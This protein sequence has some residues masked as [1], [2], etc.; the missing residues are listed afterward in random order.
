MANGSNPQ[1]NPNAMPVD[2]A[3]LRAG[4]MAGTGKPRIKLNLDG[5]YTI[6]GVNSPTAFFSP[7]NPL[8]PV[9]QADALGRAFD[10]PTGYNTRITPRGEEAI[11]FAQLKSMA[12]GFDVLRLIIETRK[13][14]VAAQ[15]WTIAPKDD[16]QERDSRCDEVQKFFERPDR[17]HVWDDWMRMV[18][19]QLFVLDAVSLYCQPTRGGDLFGLQV[20]D[21]ATIK[22]VIT[23]DG[24]TPMPDE[25][26]AYQEVIKGLPA[27]DYVVATPKGTPL[28]LDEYGQPMPE[29]FYRP[30]NVRVDRIYGYSPVEQIVT[31][32]NIA[33]HRQFYQL[34]YFTNGSTPDLIFQV[35]ET[36]NPD[37]IAKFSLYWE[38]MLR[39]NL[40]NRR[41]SM[42]VPKGVEPFDT[43]EKALKDEYDEWLTRICC[44]AFSVSPTPFIR[45][46]N[47]ATAQTHQETA[48]QQ[49]LEPVLRWITNLLND[50]IAYKFG[51]P[52]LCFKW[53]QDDPIAPTDQATI[54]VALVGAKIYH[55][56]E[57]RQKRGDEPM[58]PDMR[59][60]MD[61]ATFNAAANST[62]LP[63]EQQQAQN[64]HALAMQAAKPA[65]VVGPTP[66]AKKEDEARFEKFIAAVKQAPANI[67][68]EAPQ[69]H[70]A[71]AAV[72]VTSPPVNVTLPEM[73]QADVFVDVGPT[74]VHAKFDSPKPRTVTASRDEH[75]HLV[76]KIE[77]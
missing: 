9:A 4:S 19:E 17:Y 72:N 29:L 27:V 54:D 8:Y 77:E 49:G 36:W 51:Y 40:E 71:P 56:D 5:S 58:K 53:E 68:V 12:D 62:V 63:D 46:M 18:L 59:A 37:Q 25:G 74:T 2:P 11:G 26:P 32:V 76:A 35:P 50:V 41:G 64:D 52:D 43:K 42:F 30:R 47:R 66:E 45:Q 28:P 3:L 22:R 15:E 1:T 13:D 57:I 24:R 60:Q 44:F 14:E 16:T 7:Q 55:P 21:G 48:T 39:G 61:V 73:K 34:S 67:T 75:G 31:T 33:L 23:D 20:I 6:R 70:I 38:S 10:Y 65:P 69:V